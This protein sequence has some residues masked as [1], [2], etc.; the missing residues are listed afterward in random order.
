MRDKPSDLPLNVEDSR[1]D[2]LL[3]LGDTGRGV[4]P[5]PDSPL[6]GIDHSSKEVAKDLPPVTSPNHQEKEL[7]VSLSLSSKEDPCGHG[8]EGKQG[9]GSSLDK[10]S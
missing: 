3:S 1:S 7:A 6:E 9:K 2:E 8:Y 10:S 4:Q 5:H